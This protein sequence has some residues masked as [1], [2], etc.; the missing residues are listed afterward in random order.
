MKKI[1]LRGNGLGF[2][3]LLCKSATVLGSIHIHVKITVFVS[4]P[5]DL[6]DEMCESSIGLH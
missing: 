2:K 4:G 6:S 3:I 1:G 5:F